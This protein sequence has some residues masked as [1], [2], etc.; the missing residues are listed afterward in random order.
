MT[1]SVVGEFTDQELLKW[2]EEVSCAD[3]YTRRVDCTLM[4]VRRRKEIL[5]YTYGIILT[6]E[7]SITPL[8]LYIVDAVDLSQISRQNSVYTL[9]HPPPIRE[10]GF[11]FL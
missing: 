6:L 3:M 2:M 8:T 10:F 4:E 7:L 5:Q 9:V 11:E 1:S